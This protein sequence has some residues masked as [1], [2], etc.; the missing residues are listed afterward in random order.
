EDLR[1]HGQGHQQA[2]GGH[3]GGVRR[4]VQRAQGARAERDAGEEAIGEWNAAMRIVGGWLL[5]FA[6]WAAVGMGVRFAANAVAGTQEPLWI[7]AAMGAALGFGTAGF[8][9]LS[10]R[11]WVRGVFRDP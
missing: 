10:R 4:A 5:W 8:A 6:C 7:G 2:R 1:E 3:A 9:L 11:S